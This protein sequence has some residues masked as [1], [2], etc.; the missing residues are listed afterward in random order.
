MPTASLKQDAVGS[1][2]FYK[3]QFF[4]YNLFRAGAD[5]VH[6]LHPGHL[7]LCFQLLGDPFLFS[8]LL[9]HQVKQ[10]RS[11]VIDLDQMTIWFAADYQGYVQCLAI[12]INI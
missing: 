3:N 6:T 2:K 10:F 12:L 1:S 11:L 4:I 9:H 7:I 8:Q 5:S